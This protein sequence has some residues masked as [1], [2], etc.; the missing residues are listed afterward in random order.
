MGFVKN[1]LNKLNAVIKNK[2]AQ[3]DAQEETFQPTNQGKMDC[4][5]IKQDA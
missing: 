5:H 4:K 1:D 2:E 3:E